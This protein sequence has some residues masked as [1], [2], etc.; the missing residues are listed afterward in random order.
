MG[1]GVELNRSNGFYA[2]TEHV[3]LNKTGN[4][5]GKS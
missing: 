3:V 2:R 1:Q 5:S 4:H